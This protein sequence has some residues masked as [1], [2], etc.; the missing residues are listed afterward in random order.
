MYDICPCFLR[1]ELGEY[2]QKKKTKD[3]TKQK[4]LSLR[5]EYN[6][7]VHFHSF[8]QEQYLT[9]SGIYTEDSLLEHRLFL[10]SLRHLGFLP[11]IHTTKTVTASLLTL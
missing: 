4:T 5:N 9:K 7:T 10:C 2:V 6:S 3:K 8:S 11:I 1:F